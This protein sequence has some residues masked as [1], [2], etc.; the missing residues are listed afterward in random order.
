[1]WELNGRTEL[2]EGTTTRWHQ[3]VTMAG[4]SPAE[5]LRAIDAGTDSTTGW[6]PQPR[7]NPS[8][9]RIWT[10]T[11]DRQTRWTIALEV[12]PDPKTPSA[13]TVRATVS[14]TGG[15]TS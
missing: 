1:L 10:Y 5:V 7:A 3:V 9:T 11:D 8:A 4:K 14:S 13:T 6:R 2:T 12:G 15:R